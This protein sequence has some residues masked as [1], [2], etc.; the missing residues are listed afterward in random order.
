MVGVF[1]EAPPLLTTWPRGWPNWS[2]LR[3]PPPSGRGGSLSR[4]E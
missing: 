2:A 1:A 3:P 4:T